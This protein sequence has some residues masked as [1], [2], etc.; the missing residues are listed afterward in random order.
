M[1]TSSPQEAQILTALQA[2]PLDRIHLMKTLFLVWYRGGRPKTGPFKFRP[3]LYGPCAFDLYAALEDMEQRGIVIH[4]PYP[5]S[6]WVRYY[7]TETGRAKALRLIMDD[8]QRAQI[9]E[10]ARW[11]AEQNFQSLLNQVYQE[12][13]E[14]ASKTILRQDIR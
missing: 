13:P 4:A 7:L 11:A 12:A 3:Y 2:V 1:T 10:I 6:R 14:Y 9:V 5:S 8:E